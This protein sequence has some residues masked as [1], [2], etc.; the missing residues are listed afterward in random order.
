M[1]RIL[2]K[3]VP[4][5]PAIE[6]GPHLTQQEGWW[7]PAHLTPPITCLTKSAPIHPQENTRSQ[8]TRNGRAHPQPDRGNLQKAT[9]ADTLTGDDVTVTPNREQKAVHTSSTWHSLPDTAAKNW[10]K[11]G[12]LKLRE[13]T[14]VSIEKSQEIY[15]KM[16]WINNGLNEVVGYKVNTYCIL[17]I[18][19]KQ[20]ENEEAKLV[21]SS[22]KHNKYLE[23]RDKGLR[24]PPL[25]CLVLFSGSAGGWGA[26]S[27][28]NNDFAEYFYYSHFTDEEVEGKHQFR[29]HN[30]IRCGAG[31][32]RDTILP[33]GLEE[34]AGRM[35]E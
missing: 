35:P 17:T 1:Q 30:A 12:E 27:H 20:L 28:P 10:K 26:S 22:A 11:N 5:S 6:L 4:L 31:L 13:D 24:S 7:A 2:N 29:G 33:F 9:A 23:A 14:V 3:S 19:S 32:W 21:Y 8:Q 25:S 18:S 34:Q 15:E 16:V